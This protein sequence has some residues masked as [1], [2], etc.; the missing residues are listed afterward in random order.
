[1]PTDWIVEVRDAS[2]ARVG[3]LADLDFTD[4]LIVPRANTLGSWSIKLPDTIVDDQGV[5]VPHAMCAALRAE[6]AGIIVYGPNGFQF[7]GPMIS[8]TQDRSPEDPP[9]TWTIEGVSDT[10]QI[11][12]SIAFPQPSNSDVTTQ[13]VA[14][15]VRTDVAERLIRSFVSANIGPAA[16][17]AR[18]VAGL[19][20]AADGGHGP[21]LT[22]S[23]RFQNLLE[24]CQNIGTLGNLLFD[25]VQVGSNLQL[26]VTVPQDVS[27]S[28]RWDIDNNQ[29]Q[30]L[31]YS[32]AAPKATHV[33][34]AGQGEGT[35]RTIIEVTTPASILAAA[36]WG[37]REV[38]LDQRQTDDLGELTDAGLEILTES[39]STVK[40]LDIVP[41]SDIADGFMTDWFLGSLVSIVVGTQTVVAPIAEIPIA[42]NGDGI[43]IGAVVGDS[44]GFDWEALLY[45]KTAAL[46]S[47]VARIE[48][49]LEVPSSLYSQAQVD[50]LIAAA[51]LAAVQSASTQGNA[52]INGA[53]D[54][55]QRGTSFASPASGSYTADRTRVEW[56]GTGTRTISR[57]AFAPGTAP[58][59][60]Y[61]SAFFYR[62]AQSVAGSGGTMNNFYQ[63]PIEG[64][65]CFAGQQVTVSFWAK[66]DA[67][68]TVTP[69]LTQHFGTGGSPSG[70]VS[71][72]GAAQSVG[73][74]W[75]RYSATVT[76]PSIAGKTI[77]TSGTDA[78]ILTLQS[79]TL[80]AT[81]TI[82]IWGVQVESGPTATAFV[83]A[84]R[85]IAGEQ[86][87]CWRYYQFHD[88]IVGSG[89]SAGY[90]FAVNPLGQL[91]RA[92]PATLIADTKSGPTMGTVYSSNTNQAAL[93]KGGFYNGQGA[94]AG[95]FVIFTNVII[96]AEL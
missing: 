12:N 52:I 79:S 15:D 32:Y 96:S 10:A 86:S 5:R 66:A 9:G 62:F 23:P 37:R 38:F 46:E 49:T 85:T 20:L 75:Q 83:R 67:A 50:S 8:A 40:S 80:N 36:I 47:R 26:Q 76:V 70:N 58:V 2:R 4:V 13:T 24:L 31:R 90:K 87:L 55:W 17:V 34:V 51:R 53:F 89:D 27:S 41:S 81:Q 64:V 54:F 1:M 33:Y 11:A 60:G 3:Q 19:T 84:G 25:V 56:N 22:R 71:T 88:Y 82:D 95:A 65:R 44:T 61:E 74:T 6:N 30:R 57:Q 42:I 43:F 39:G 93:G 28:V 21:T 18:K 45:G 69:I 92:T 48:T 35:D 63:Q 16:T 59:A 94:T 77:G 7:N 78:L 91:L 14:N 29:I 68:R 73:T 72:N